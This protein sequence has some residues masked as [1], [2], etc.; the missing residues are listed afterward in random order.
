MFPHN[1]INLSQRRVPISLNNLGL[2]TVLIVT[3]CGVEL[4]WVMSVKADETQR[5]RAWPVV[6]L[7]AV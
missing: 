5:R 7:T 4:R 2:I 6:W 1:S 3:S